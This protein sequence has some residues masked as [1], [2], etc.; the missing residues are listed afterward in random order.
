MENIIENIYIYILYSAAVSPVGQTTPEWGG[1][2][3]DERP[4][5]DEQAT[6]ARIH[7]H[8][9]EIDAHQREQRSERRVEEE[10]ECLDGEKFLV[11]RTEYQF[12]QVRLAPYSVGRVLG[13]GILFRVHL[14]KS[15]GVD[16]GTNAG[17]GQ[18]GPS[19][20]AGHLVR[21]RH[22]NNVTSLTTLKTK[23]T[24]RYTVSFDDAHVKT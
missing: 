6:L 19:G 18:R 20:I 8:L 2:K 5:P 11:D 9:F 13:L 15:F 16:T 7:T 10:V 12:D 1:Q 23:T 21:R 3:L 17:R 4:G 22:A 14:A 24:G